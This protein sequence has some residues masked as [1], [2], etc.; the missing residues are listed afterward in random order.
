MMLL[1]ETDAQA[2]LWAIET[3]IEAEGEW[4]EGHWPSEYGTNWLQAAMEKRLKFERLAIVLRER[5]WPDSR[6]AEALAVDAGKLAAT[7]LRK[8]ATDSTRTRQAAGE[9]AAHGAA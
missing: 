4:F 3:A 7:I 2:L 6:R 8:C 1:N 9:G 5:A